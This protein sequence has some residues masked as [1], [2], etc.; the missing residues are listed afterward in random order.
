MLDQI[1]KEYV[2]EIEAYRENPVPP[3]SRADALKLLKR[4]SGKGFADQWQEPVTPYLP[5]V[6]CGIMKLA[7]TVYPHDEAITYA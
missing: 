1:N 4:F 3:C 7:D 6:S 5:A 2:A